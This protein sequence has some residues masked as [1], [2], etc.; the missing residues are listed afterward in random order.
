MT[1]IN[2]DTW[3]TKIGIGVMIALTVGML[4]FFVDLRDFIKYKQPERDS[5]Q[6]QAISNNNT[7]IQ[8]SDSMTCY[9]ISNVNKRQDDTKSDINQI[10]ADIEFIKNFIIG[11]KN[12]LTSNK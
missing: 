10:K 2:K 12:K 8:I 7:K 6:D 5:R 4:Y 3:Y 1:K 9:K 11:N